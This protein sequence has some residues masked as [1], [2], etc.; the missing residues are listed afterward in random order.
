[1][2]TILAAEAPNGKHLAGDLNEVYWGSAAFF[3]LM[4]LLSAVGIGRQPL[5]T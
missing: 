4:A 5:L 1:M 2:L 3:V